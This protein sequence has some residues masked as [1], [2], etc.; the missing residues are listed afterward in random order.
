MKAERQR[1]CR[2]DNEDRLN[3]AAPE[4]QGTPKS[5]NKPPEVRKQQRKEAPTVFR[6]SR[7]HANVDFGHF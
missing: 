1:E 6:G 7:G 4:F 5:G 2:Y 3:Y